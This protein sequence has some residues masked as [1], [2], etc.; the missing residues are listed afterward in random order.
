MKAIFE[1]R[2]WTC[3]LVGALAAGLAAGCWLWLWKAR[4][5]A[6]VK[7]ACDCFR[8]EGHPVEFWLI[9]GLGHTWASE[10]GINERIWQFL[11]R[12]ALP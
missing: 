2:R 11:A 9:E 6:T 8:Q 7:E 10:H 5:P 1:K 4:L 3:W 12:H